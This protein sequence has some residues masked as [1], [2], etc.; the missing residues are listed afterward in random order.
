[1]VEQKGGLTTAKQLL[2]M[3]GPQQ[4]LIRLKEVGHLDKCME[5]VVLKERFRLLF[6]DA[7]IDEARRRLKMLGFLNR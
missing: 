7:E 4:G 5:A 3:T 6:T 2:E 1:M